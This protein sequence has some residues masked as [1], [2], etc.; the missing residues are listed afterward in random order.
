MR[1]GPFAYGIADMTAGWGSAGQWPDTAASGFIRA[2]SRAVRGGS[3]A[4]AGQ[5]SRARTLLEAELRHCADAA[6][7]VLPGAGLGAALL[8]ADDLPGAARYLGAAT[9]ADGDASLVE[10]GRPP[11][12]RPR[13]TSGGRWVTPAR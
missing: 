4:A 13:R 1:I 11:R 6:G 5:T 3:L 9:T 12:E 2:C 8:Y 10:S 7:R